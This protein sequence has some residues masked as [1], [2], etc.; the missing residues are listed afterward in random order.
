[1]YYYR[2][3]YFITSTI[4]SIMHPMDAYRWHKHTRSLDDMQRL[5][6]AHED[7]RKTGWPCG[8]NN[9][10]D[11]LD[12]EKSMNEIQHIVLTNTWSVE[13]TEDEWRIILGY[14][15]SSSKYS[16]T[17]LAWKIAS[18]ADTNLKLF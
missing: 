5:R 12:K 14:L 3:K 17:N 2:I 1:M 7:C 16:D 10:L 18:S 6:K 4:W 9:V 8:I 11:A 15:M 13:L